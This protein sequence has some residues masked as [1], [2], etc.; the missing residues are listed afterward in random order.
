MR[1]AKAAAGSTLFFAL[2]PGIVAGLA[3]WWLTGWA[4]GRTPYPAAARIAGF[5]LLT[6]GA[7]VLIESF[8]R[9]TRDGLGTPAPTAPT[10]RLVVRGLYRYVRNPMYLAVLAAIVG[11]GLALSRPVLF[12]YAAAVAACVVTFVYYYEQPALTRQFGARYE[13]YQ[14]DVPAWLPRMRPAAPSQPDDRPAPQDPA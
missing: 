11:Q 5:V 3:P 7:L 8:A 12:G 14:R 1:K 6:A 13:A 10:E 4:S 9:F 2:A